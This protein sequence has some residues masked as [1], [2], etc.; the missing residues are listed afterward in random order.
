MQYTEMWAM[1]VEIQGAH[2]RGSSF[3]LA[4]KAYRKESHLSGDLKNEEALFR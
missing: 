3:R 4:E 1:V 2:W